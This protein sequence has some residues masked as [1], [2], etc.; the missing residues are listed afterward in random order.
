MK[1]K[2]RRVGLPS[3][4]EGPRFTIWIWYSADP[5]DRALRAG[6]CNYT[7]GTSGVHLSLSAPAKLNLFLAITG[8]RADG[9]HSLVSVVAPLTLS[10]T[11]TV[12]LRE[13][14]TASPRFDL[15]CDDPAVPTD[16]SNLVL[17]AAQAFADAAGWQGG[18]RFRLEKKIPAGAGLGGGS[19]DAVATLRGLNRACGEP[20]SRADLV[21]I[22]AKLGSDCPLFLRDGPVVMRGRGE[23][24]EDLPQPGLSRLRGRR[25]LI[26]KPAFG[27]ATAWAYRRLAEMAATAKN[28]AAINDVYVPTTV[29]ERRLQTWIGEPSASPEELLFNNLERPAFAKHVALPTLLEQMRRDFGLVP[30]MTGSGSACFAFLASTAPLAAIRASIVSKWGDSAYIVETSLA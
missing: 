22:A 13:K 27:I 14:E 29:A 30:L 10:D 4:S 9:F 20:L 23:D 6:W 5:A 26:F 8:R 1:A 15:T 7:R 12:E 2:S 3:R 21:G 28:G 17:R 16:G 18:A 25:V 11:I 24:V 19:S